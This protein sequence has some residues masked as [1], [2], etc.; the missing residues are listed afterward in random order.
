MLP[1]LEGPARRYLVLHDT[2][3]DP[4]DSDPVTHQYTPNNVPVRTDPKDFPAS[5]ALVH[6]YHHPEQIR[7]DHRWIDYFVDFDNGDKR[8]NG[9]EFVEG[10]W[11]EKLGLVAIAA[12]VAIVVVSIVWCVKGGDLQT[13]F[14]VMGFVLTFVAAE[15]ALVALYYQIISG[16]TPSS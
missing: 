9:L 10:L 15:I 2:T 3:I 11:A 4:E 1:I 5:R 14:T 12:S 7:P 16:N 8:Q 6:A 13:V